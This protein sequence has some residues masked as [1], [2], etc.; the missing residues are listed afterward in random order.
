[1]YLNRDIITLEEAQGLLQSVNLQTK[2]K[3]ISTA[4]AHF[5]VLAENIYATFPIPAFRRSGYDGYGILNEDDHSFPREFEI[6]DN[7]GAGSVLEKKMSSGQAVRIMTGAKVP[8]EVGKVTMLEVTEKCSDDKVL[9]KESMKH[10]N[11]S[12][13]GE[14]FLKGDLLLSSGTR[15]NA[16]AISLLNAFGI[17]EVLVYQKPKV[18]I[19]ATGS[20]LLKAGEAYVEG[21]IYNSNGPLLEALVRENGGLVITLDN[22]KD[23][24]HD[25]LAI[26]NDLTSRCDLVLT[27]GGVSVGDFDFMAEAAKAADQFLFNK[28]SMRPG[29]PTTAFVHKGTP[30]IALS[31]NPGACFTGFYLFVEPTLQ[32]FVGGKSRLKQVKL[33]LAHDYDKPNNFDK[34]LRATVNFDHDSGLIV[35]QIG[36]DKSSALGNLH[37]TTAFFK[38]P[39]DSSIHKGEEVEVWLLPY[40]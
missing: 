17:A 33:P 21:K 40:K 25:T 7:I 22:V 6:I 10:S 35:S 38:V 31:G 8:D 27:T 12:S 24:L 29:S 30:V 28:L 13:I 34:Y 39:H 19:L 18:G 9:I 11:I 16:G 3:K 5:Y 15:L 14:E 1:M 26:L 23:E 37:S 36:S 2:T 20:E 4:E 32:R